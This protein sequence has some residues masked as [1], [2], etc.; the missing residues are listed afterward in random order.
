MDPRIRTA[1]WAL[2]GLA[3]AVGISL[4]AFAVAGETIGEPAGHVRVEPTLDE[5]QNSPT[6]K[7]THTKEPTE[8]PEP[9]ETRTST[10]TFTSTSTS[11]ATAQPAPTDDHAG[12]NSG[13][14]GSH[15]GSDD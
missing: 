8:T 4:T 12:D 5:E 13:S 2:A 11:T 7:P 14:G 15:D 1:L 6:P 3:L 10:V 9:T